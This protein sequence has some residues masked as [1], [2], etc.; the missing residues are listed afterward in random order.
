MPKLKAG[1]LWLIPVVL[2]T[3]DAEIRRMEDQSQ[4]GQRV[5]QTLFQKT[6]SQKWA[7]GV[8]EDVGPEFK[9]QY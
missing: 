7:D 8:A 3:Q 2:A 9:P 6:T 5:S 1:G 4:P